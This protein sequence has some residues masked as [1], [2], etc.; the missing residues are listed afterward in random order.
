MLHKET[1]NN[2][3]LGYRGEQF[4][5]RY[6]EQKG[7]ICV[8][9]NYCAQGGEVDLICHDKTADEYVL[10]EVKTRRNTKFSALEDT[11][12]PGKFEKMERAAER[13]F[14][15][16]QNMDEMPLYRIDIVLV[17]P[18]ENSTLVHHIKNQEKE[19]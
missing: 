13:Y 10:V 15:V 8:A 17:E 5:K 14:L 12:H 18:K 6:L 3:E 4:A 16:D 11:I 7:Y 2:K 9:E 19:L 1:M